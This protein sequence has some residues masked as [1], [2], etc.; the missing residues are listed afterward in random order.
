MAQLVRMATNTI[1]RMTSYQTPMC[2]HLHKYNDTVR[3]KGRRGPPE[4]R[5]GT[6]SREDG[7]PL[8]GG[9]G[10]SQGKTGTL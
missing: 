6:F 9:R 3:I 2:L 5:T 7:D 4:G 8:K 1:Q 10:P